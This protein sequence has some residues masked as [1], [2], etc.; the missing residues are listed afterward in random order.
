M[1][2]WALLAAGGWAATLW[3]GEPSATAGPRPAPASSSAPGDAAPGPQPE[4]GSCATA[5]ATPSPVASAAPLLKAEAM[6]TRS[7]QRLCV[8]AVTR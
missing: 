8:H 1:T 7:V 3:L 5:R 4:G 6:D 2:G